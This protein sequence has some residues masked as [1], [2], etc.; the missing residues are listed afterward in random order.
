[1]SLLFMKG[2]I[3]HSVKNDYTSCDRKMRIALTVIIFDMPKPNVLPNN[4]LTLKGM[5][6]TL[7]IR[8]KLCQ[9]QYVKV[10][11]T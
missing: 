7:T 8:Y 6:P 11:H 2:K 9:L 1:M 3:E 4:F 10:K 5:I